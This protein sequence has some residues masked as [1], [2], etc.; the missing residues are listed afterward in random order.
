MVKTANGKLENNK[1][2]QHYIIDLRKGYDW[3]GE[4]DF[5]GRMLGRSMGTGFMASS[6]AYIQLTGPLASTGSKKVD[7]GA[8]I[9][10]TIVIREQV[11]DDEFIGIMSKGKDLLTANVWMPWQDAMYFHQV[12]MSG[13]CEMLEIAGTE[14]YRRHSLLRR[15]G[16]NWKYE[17]D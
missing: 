6:H 3:A 11:E 5:A 4:I 14:L 12:L 16:L 17:W 1:T 15:V 9:D 8:T 7:V 13:R 2:W 10:L